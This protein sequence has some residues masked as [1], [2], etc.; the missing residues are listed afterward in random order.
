M[1]DL[2]KNWLTEKYIDFEYKKYVLLAWLQEVNNNF[3]DQKLY[4]FLAQLI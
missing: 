2:N 4:P 3:Q 1:A